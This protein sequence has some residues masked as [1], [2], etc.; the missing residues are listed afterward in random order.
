[1]GRAGVLGRVGE[2]FGDAEIEGGLD[3]RVQA[4]AEIDADGGFER[5]VQGESAYGIDQP[6]L[7]QQRRADAPDQVAE[8]GQGRGGPRSRLPQQRLGPVG[9]GLHQLLHGRQGHPERDHARLRSIV[10]VALDAPDLGGLR[11]RRVRALGRQL[12]HPVGQRHRRRRPQE[13]DGHRA[14]RPPGV[15]RGAGRHDHAEHPDEAHGGRRMSEPDD[16]HHDSGR[17]DG[18]DQPHGE[19]GDQCEAQVTP[20]GGIAPPEPHPLVPARVPAGALVGESVP[21]ISGRHAHHRPGLPISGRNDGA[22]P[23]R[24]EGTGHPADRARQGE[25]ADGRPQDRRYRRP[26][27]AAPPPHPQPCGGGPHGRDQHA[28]DQHD[29]RSHESHGGARRPRQRLSHP[30]SFVLHDPGP[31]CVP[32]CADPAW[33]LHCAPR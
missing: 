7:G 8:L 15:R 12:V 10:Q 4:Q 20:G 18:R 22:R 16:R 17:W 1:M 11:D 3:R 23:L 31:R 26:R 2:Q 32:K 24:H 21:P 33:C 25:R 13:P 30:C 9:V 27:V 19:R 14:D 29:A 5:A 28:H 6:A